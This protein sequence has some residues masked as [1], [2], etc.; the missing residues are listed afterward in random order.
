MFDVA[1]W[2]RANFVRTFGRSRRLFVCVVVDE[3]V[4]SR[5]GTWRSRVVCPPRAEQFARRRSTRWPREGPGEHSLG[6]PSQ[7][8]ETRGTSGRGMHSFR[9]VEISGSRLCR[10]RWGYEWP[11]GGLCQAARGSGTA[12]RPPSGGGR[13]MPF[14]SV[15]FVWSA[16]GSGE[17]LSP[18]TKSY[19]F[20]CLSGSVCAI[21]RSENTGID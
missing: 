18:S 21:A 20:V 6:D 11:R 14:P 19:D 10:R 1:A 12:T 17:T 4:Q 8:V 3:L 7:R 15:G 16:R 13:E 5:A 2:L 9:P